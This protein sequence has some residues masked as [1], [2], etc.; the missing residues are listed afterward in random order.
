M[1]QDKKENTPEGK[2]NTVGHY[3]GLGELFFY[4]FRKKKDRPSN[5]NIKVMHGINRISIVIFLLAII[6]L[7]FRRL[8]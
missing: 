7:I 8:F 3:F 5:F 4:F 2:R 1:E 6:F